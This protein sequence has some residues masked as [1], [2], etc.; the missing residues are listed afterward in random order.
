MYEYDG[1]AVQ[2]IIELAGTGALKLRNSAGAESVGLLPS[3]IGKRHFK[4]QKAIQRLG[5]R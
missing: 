1:D 2:D 3:K 4:L 5:S